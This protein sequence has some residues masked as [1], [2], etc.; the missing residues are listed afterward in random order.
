MKKI[1]KLGTTRFL[2]E[3]TRNQERTVLFGGL[4]RTL[5]PNAPWRKV[6]DFVQCP[7][8]LFVSIVVPIR[9]G[10]TIDAKGGWFAADFL[11]DVYFWVDIFLNFVTGYEDDDGI[12]VMNLRKISSMYF[13]SWFWVDIVASLPIDL[14]IKLS[15]GTFEC[16]LLDN[17]PSEDSAANS[18]NLLKLF[19]ILR[20]T[21]LVK[22]LRLARI[23]R[24]LEKYQDDLFYIEPVIAVSKF[25]LVL[26]FLGH[27]FGCF[28]YYFSTKQFRNMNEKNIIA[29]DEGLAAQP[30]I[31]AEFGSEWDSVHVPEC[32][33]QTTCVHCP[34]S[35][36]F[37]GQNCV[38]L[39]EFKDRYIASLYW[40]FTT[41]TTVG[42]GDISASTNAERLS[43]VVGMILGG[44]VF[45]AIIGNMTATMSR[46][47]L[48]QVAYRKKIDSV[49]LFLREA[50]L[51]KKLRDKVLVF[52]RTQAVKSYDT[53]HLLELLP[54]NLRINVVQEIYGSIIAR[55]PFL[56]ADNE[57]LIADVCV[58]LQHL[59]AN[60]GV[61]IYQK[62][63]TSGELYIIY[64]GTVE[65]WED[66]VESQTSK[67]QPNAQ[68]IAE[69]KEESGDADNDD[70]RPSMSRPASGV[71]VQVY[72]EGSY[73]GESAAM[74]VVMQGKSPTEVERTESVI[75][76]YSGVNLLFLTISDLIEI[77]QTYPKVLDQLVSF[78]KRKYDKNLQRKNLLQ[79]FKRYSFNAPGDGDGD[80]TSFLEKVTERLDSS[81]IQTLASDGEGDDPKSTNDLLY[82]SASVYRP[83]ATSSALRDDADPFAKADIVLGAALTIQAKWRKW[84][85]NA[86][87][88]KNRK[89]FEGAFRKSTAN[90]KNSLRLAKMGI[91]SPSQSETAVKAVGLASGD[92]YNGESGE[93]ISSTSQIIQ[94]LKNL[95]EDIDETS[96]EVSTISNAFVHELAHLQENLYSNTA[97]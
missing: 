66:E 50:A 32:V 28:F 82:Q 9:I 72:R 70:S 49:S 37:D 46:R 40:A 19:R 4:L 97:M 24:I 8:L 92:V 6:W 25:I 71:P 94:A 54:F 44:V 73:F 11:I 80:A 23:G 86:L 76:G 18:A 55:V 31:L 56:D 61:S 1:S 79:T 21:R 68:P 38:N 39:Y 65:M 12:Q 29:D 36:R 5:Y 95:Q 26:M 60:A 93:W 16:T 62:E 41:M 42:Y 69:S 27:L 43:A 53:R 47:N 85:D 81:K 7:V 84:K 83:D 3:N 17:C 89:G 59:N 77:T 30:W 48:N 13:R 20:L 57:M 34:A 67:W 64:H 78:Y 10:F 90:L 74:Q 14:A 88:P 58:R 96:K 52:F 45:S 75:A 91:K 33:G 63:E 2:A 15:T 22:L 87:S 35:A 51:P